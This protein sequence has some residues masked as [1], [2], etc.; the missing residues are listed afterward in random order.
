M[1]QNSTRGTQLYS[2]STTGTSIT[3]TPNANTLYSSIPNSQSGN[4]VYSA[5]YGT[6]TTKSGTYKIKGTEKPDFSGRVDVYSES[7]YSLTGDSHKV[8]LGYSNM[9]ATIPYSQK[10]TAKNYSSI[11]T[12]KM[13]V[14]SKKS[15]VS[16]SSDS[17]VSLPKIT[18]V[19]SNQATISAIDTRG[20]STS[21]TVS[22]TAIN[23]FNIKIKNLY[24]YYII[25][26]V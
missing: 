10:A 24:Y 17:A 21:K 14:G 16:E 18:A 3:F 2:G 1:Y 9:M 22:L 6:T 5:T 25:V 8:I 23:Y 13:V 20:L 4:C 19:T 11:K 12:Y 26:K 7:H 15:S